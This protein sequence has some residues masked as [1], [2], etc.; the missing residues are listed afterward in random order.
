MANI[1]VAKRLE[2]ISADLSEVA[3][4][5]WLYHGIPEKDAMLIDTQATDIAVQAAS[6]AALAREARGDRRA[7]DR[8]RKAVRRA[9]GFTYP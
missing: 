7:P 5:I 3:K 4:F 9:L 2:R 6:V 1:N 8:I